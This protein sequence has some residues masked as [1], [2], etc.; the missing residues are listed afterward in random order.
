MHLTFAYYIIKYLNPDCH[1][2]PFH[3]RLDSSPSESRTS[4]IRYSS[5]VKPPSRRDKITIRQVRSSKKH[6]QN[7]FNGVIVTC[8]KIICFKQFVDFSFLDETKFPGFSVSRTAGSIVGLV[9]VEPCLASTTKRYGLEYVAYPEC[10]LTFLV[11]KT[12]E[13]RKCRFPPIAPMPGGSG[14]SNGISENKAKLPAPRTF[15][16]S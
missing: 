4:K 10:F 1:R 3:L 9:S 6:T 11:F 8:L 7:S 16:A 14:C 15:L 13:E 5:R 12:R 2:R